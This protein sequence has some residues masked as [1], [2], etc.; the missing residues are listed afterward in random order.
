[1]N[2]N[3]FLCEKLD[4]KIQEEAM[5]LLNKVKTKR[6]PNHKKKVS[7]IPSKNGDKSCSAFSV[8]DISSQNPTA[9]TRQGYLQRLREDR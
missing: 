7:S 1:M 8:L 6:S 5:A 2:D 4:K 3:Q 9:L